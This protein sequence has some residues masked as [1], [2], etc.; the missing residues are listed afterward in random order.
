MPTYRFR[1]V[2]ETSLHYE[3]EVTLDYK[4]QRIVFSFPQQESQEKAAR[5]SVEV[6]AANWGEADQKAQ[7]LLQPVLDAIAFATGLPLLVLHW[8]FVLKDEAGSSTR[9]ALWSE[10]TKGL[11]DFHWRK[12]RLTLRRR[13][14]PK[15]VAQNWRC[16]GTDMPSNES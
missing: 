15:R 14:F 13:F 16:A 11:F 4:G 5:A 7:S 6:E 10:T 9:K 2:C 12:L 3:K 8:D 1:Y